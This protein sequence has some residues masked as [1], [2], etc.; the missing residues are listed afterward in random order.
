[1]PVTDSPNLGSSSAVVWPP[2]STAPA[3]VILLS[4]PSTMP[5]RISGPSWSVGKPIKLRQVN[6]SFD[7]PFNAQLDHALNIDFVNEELGLEA[8]VA[9]ELSPDS[10]RRMV[11]AI[12]VALAR[13]E[14]E[15]GLVEEEG[16]VSS[17]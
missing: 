16:G 15:V 9:V 3:S 7:H 6:V 2:A 12:G 5:W 11:E 13:G 17:V 1:M 8:R 14:E 10:A 4:A